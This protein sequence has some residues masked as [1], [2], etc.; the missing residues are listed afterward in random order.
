MGFLQLN[1]GKNLTF[2]N[3]EIFQVT[4][5]ESIIEASNTKVL[6]YNSKIIFNKIYGPIIS[7]DIVDSITIAGNSLFRN[8]TVNTE[9]SVFTVTA[10]SGFII[11]MNM[12]QNGNIMEFYSP[13]GAGAENVEIL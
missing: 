12:I 9:E 1:N 13:T 11:M 8:N 3:S 2:I 4:N 10:V 7:A 5:W 6:I